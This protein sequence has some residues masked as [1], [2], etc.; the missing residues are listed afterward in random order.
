MNNF[1]KNEKFVLKILK[2]RFPDSILNGQELILENEQLSIK[3]KVPDIQQHR[4]NAVTA[5][6]VYLIEHPLFDETLIEVCAGVGED[7]SSALINAAESF[8]CGVAVSIIASL[9]CTGHSD[10][11][12]LTSSLSGKETAFRGACGIP[13]L[14]SGSVPASTD[15]WGVIKEFIPKYLGTK[16]AYWIKLFVAR[17][18]ENI[19]AEVRINNTVYPD[20]SGKLTEYAE[21]TFSGEI[22]DSQKEFVL[23]IREKPAESKFPSGQV[24]QYAIRA[25][26]IIKSTKNID[27]AMEKIY[28]MCK[29]MTLAYELAMFT[30]EIYA[31]A[32]LDIEEPDYVY[33][34]R[35]GVKTPVKRSV[36]RDYGYIESGVREYI[37]KARPNGDENLKIMGFSSKL[38]VVHKLIMQGSKIENIKFEGV[39]YNVPDYFEIR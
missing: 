19:T 5:E 14:R 21:K 26:D 23:L 6:T 31:Q 4:P 38:Y 13:V 32:V 8:Y 22:Y 20:I 9:R 36:I 12:S 7:I 11:F 17:S 15:L 3:V 39:Y 29:D 34:C 24:K 16:N 18:K 10:K 2:K 1:N 30:P 27:A 28:F 37:L 25:V 33:I 35:G